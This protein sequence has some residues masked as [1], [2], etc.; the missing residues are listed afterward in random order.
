MKCV[1]VGTRPAAGNHEGIN[2]LLSP[3]LRNDK[4]IEQF[5]M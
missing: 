5:S 2:S 4:H 1:S 3:S